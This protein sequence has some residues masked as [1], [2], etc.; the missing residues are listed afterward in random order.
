[1]KKLILKPWPVLLLLA[2]TVACDDDDDGT[3]DPQPITF[4]E[5][6]SE[7][8]RISLMRDDA[9]DLLQANTGEIINT[10]SG[11]LVENTRYYTSNS[12][13]YLTAIDRNGNM[14]RFFDSGVIN[15][16]DHGH[17]NQPAWLQISIDA[18]LPTHYASSGGHI[19]I[20]NDGDASITHIN[21]A[22]LELPAYT[23]NVMPLQNTVAHHGAGFR[24]DNGKFA[25]TFKNTTE[26]GGLP[27][28]V[29]FVDADGNVI[30]D[31][32]NVEVIGIHG[33]ATNGEYGAFGSTDGVILVDNQDNISL[34]ENIE[35]L[36]S[37]SGNWIGT[38][39]AH[40]NSDLFFGRSRNLGVYIIDPED[41]SL[42]SLYS[43]DDVA[44]D[45]INF[46]GKYYILHTNDNMIRVYNTSDGSAVANR[47]VEMVDIP[48]LAE[49]GRTFSSEVEVLRQMD[50]P[51]PVLICSDN[52]LYILAPN[53]QQIKVLA[54][55][56]L[57]H[58]HTIDLGNEVSSM[59]KNG[60]TEK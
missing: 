48:D 4:Q 31:N 2:L 55:N 3:G 25:T 27:Q 39:K 50:E 8:V 51:S 7:W 54:I 14:V 49:T 35:G 13:R 30:D 1:M 45:M 26:P 60:F 46:D 16:D 37:E 58:V 42:T 9:I 44:G 41:Q 11:E 20:F 24:L 28:M 57:T 10:I 21:E 36:N 56:D 19:V 6:E 15:H 12:G 47:V 38:L 40:D 23:P 43:G 18:P 17:Q 59:I 29:K 34:I 52:F 32:G 53:R 5:M 33:D 22:Q